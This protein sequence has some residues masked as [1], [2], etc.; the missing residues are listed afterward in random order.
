MSEWNEIVNLL[1]EW[2]QALLDVERTRDLGGVH[3]AFQKAHTLKGLLSMQGLP[4]AALALHH[5]E[6]SLDRARRSGSLEELSF[7][8]LFR[9]IDRFRAVVSSGRDWEELGSGPVAQSP[10]EA[11]PSVAVQVWNGELSPE[12]ERLIQSHEQQGIRLWI[13]QKIFRTDLAPGLWERLPVFRTLAEVG[14]LYQCQPGPQDWDRSQ[15]E[16]VVS[17]LFGSAKSHAELTALLYDPVFP[18]RLP[19]SPTGQPRTNERPLRV[20]L[21]EDDDLTLRLLTMVLQHQSY[22][23]TAC[24]NGVEGW[25]EWSAAVQRGEPFDVLIL[26]QMIPGISGQDLLVRVR[27]QEERLGTPRAR[28]ARVFINTAL[29]DYEFVRQAFKNQADG[30]FIKPYTLDKILGALEKVRGE[31]S[32]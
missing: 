5:L 12:T 32:G 6:D 21:V 30:Y 11:S 3:L 1:D 26:D 27:D 14:F 7:D 29:D 8:T 23:V 17:F 13:L 16:V 18:A 4:R 9:A 15:P 24:V 20:L 25:E 31:I 22:Q 2:E 10:A 28:M 19:A